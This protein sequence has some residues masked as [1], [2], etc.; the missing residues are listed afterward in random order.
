V[1]LK[2]AFEALIP[3]WTYPDPI[4]T[5]IRA[6]SWTTIATGLECAFE[7]P[8]VVYGFAPGVVGVTPSTR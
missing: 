1:G 3:L 6:L 2:C 8:T 4:A 5:T 7:I